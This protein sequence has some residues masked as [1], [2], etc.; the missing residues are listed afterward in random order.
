[1]HSVCSKFT[2]IQL[3]SPENADFFSF[4]TYIAEKIQNYGAS[5]QKLRHHS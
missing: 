2:K 1:M 3:N 4:I 5:V